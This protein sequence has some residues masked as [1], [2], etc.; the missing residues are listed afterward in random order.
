M[1]IE[2][3][4]ENIN[5]TGLTRKLN[6]SND[7]EKQSGKPFTTNDVNQ[8]IQLGHLPYYMGGNRIDESDI[9][10]NGMKLYNLRK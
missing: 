7:F 8:Y 4:Y 10:V 2:Y 1:I 9:R 5:L 6:E 3:L